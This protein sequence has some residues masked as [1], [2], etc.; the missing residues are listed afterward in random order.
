[1]YF[2]GFAIM[3]IA[4]V[5][6]AAIYEKINKEGFWFRIFIAFIFWGIFIVGLHTCVSSKENEMESHIRAIMDNKIT[7]EIG[8]TDIIGGKESFTTMVRINY[9]DGELTNFDIIPG[10]TEKVE[11]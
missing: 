6:Y 3:S 1:M 8:E 4:I 10:S 2:I 7:G 5:I 9:K 11:K